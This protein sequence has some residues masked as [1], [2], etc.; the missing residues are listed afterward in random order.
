M[1]VEAIAADLQ[2]LD[3]GEQQQIPVNASAHLWH[4]ANRALFFAYLGIATDRQAPLDQA[5]GLL[6]RILDELPK[7][8]RLKSSLF[9]GVSG[10]GWT[11]HHV[12]R[13]LDAHDDQLTEALDAAL[14]QQLAVP[15][16]PGRPYDLMDGL[17]GMGV[18]AF[19]ASQE[20]LLHRVV[21]QLRHCA[22]TDGDGV[23]WWVPE[24]VHR[25]EAGSD[26]ETR[27]QHNLGLAHG[28]A[29]VIAFLADALTGEVLPETTEP[30]L[31]GA[32]RWLLSQG[33]DT[34][35]ARRGIEPGRT[36]PWSVIP[37]FT[38]HI[39][40]WDPGWAYADSGIAW[41]LLR[42]ARVLRERDL[43][44]RALDVARAETERLA[45]IPT[46]NPGIGY[47]PAGFVLLHQR[48]WQQTGDPA[49]QQA[50]LQAVEQLLEL[51]SSSAEETIGGFS[52]IDPR[53]ARRPADTGLLGGA[54]GIGL[55]LLTALFEVDAT[56]DRLL[57]LS[58]PR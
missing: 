21:E 5:L 23:S 47:G 16:R 42:A 2:R 12:G 53:G 28:I 34:D 36:F 32:V 56:W 51:R 26:T 13:L 9:Y 48:L 7:A 22:Q 8:Q 46:R 54:A 11:L 55:V 6:Q 44:R 52:T 1:T 30:L 19:E 27:H 17:V 40:G 58:P 4:L 35:T 37:G 24:P 20:S 45:D 50:A 14:E 25:P 31:R 38:P 33:L 41:A 39:S 49:F 43:E 29:G 10:L 15:A 57:L 18:Y 3:E